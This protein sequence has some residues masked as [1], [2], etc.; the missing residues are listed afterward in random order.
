MNLKIYSIKKN[1][2]YNRSACKNNLKGTG[3]CSFFFLKIGMRYFFIPG[4]R[5]ENEFI[6]KRNFFS[7]D[8]DTCLWTCPL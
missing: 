8:L 3:T 5:N 6:F 7:T 1:I 2:I 4:K